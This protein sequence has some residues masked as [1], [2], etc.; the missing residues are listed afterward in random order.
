[1]AEIFDSNMGRLFVQPDGPNGAV[2]WLG[3]HDVGDITQAL[4]E[5][6]IT[7]CRDPKRANGAKLAMRAQGQKS[8]GTFDVTFPIGKTADWLEIIERKP[9]YTPFYIQLGECAE[10]N[11]FNDFER[12][13]VIQDCKITN[14]TDSGWS[15]RPGAA[16]GE[17]TRA[18]T[19]SFFTK[20]DY[21]SLVATRWASVAA[22]ALLGITAAGRDRCMGPCGA[23]QDGC[24]ILY[25]TDTAGA[26]AKTV[27]Y[28][29]A[30]F[31]HT[32]A[33]TT[34][35]NFLVDEDAGPIVA[36]PMSATV[37][38]VMAACSE[39]VAA[40]P[41]KVCYSDD[42][43]VTWTDVLTVGSTNTEWI[44][45]LFAW[46]SEAIFAC[47]DTGAGAAGN[48]YLSE[49]G[50]LTWTIVLTGATDSLNAITFCSRYQG[51]TVGDTNE[52]QW[53]EDGGEHWT[54][55]TGPAAQAAANC[56]SAVVLDDKRWFV[57]YDDGEVWFTQDGGTTWTERDLPLPT[58]AT[59]ITTV[60][61]MV[62]IDDYNLWLGVTATVGGNPFAAIMRTVNGGTNWESHLAP[63][64]GATGI[65]DL[66]ACSYNRAFGV[67][68]V[69][70]ATGLILEVAEKA[71]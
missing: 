15:T 20:E 56:L 19:L 1:M 24:E 28:R 9:C 3:C 58:G 8:L 64:T 30:D 11:V 7:F 31:G 12:G 45:D 33:A 5:E 23:A 59:A 29:S 46:S 10:P 39:T 71:G 57:G 61:A 6:A 27:V 13:R 55:I 34:A 42:D 32:W 14:D 35:L 47:T 48:V 60:P 62:A 70:A 51:L 67:G 52:I 25:C 18:F 63:A 69:S 40:Q 36:F 54:V 4:G 21:F 17:A 26:A 68:G 2:Y 49:D 65:A 22:T 16:P 41:A 66:V 43:G 37:M 44:N 38:R 50:G 53:T